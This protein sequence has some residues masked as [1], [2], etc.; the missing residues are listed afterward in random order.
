MHYQYCSCTVSTVHALS[1]L[2]VSMQ[3]TLQD[4]S[5]LQ[6]CKPRQDSL[7]Q[8]AFKSQMNESIKGLIVHWQAWAACIFALLVVLIA[9]GSKTLRADHNKGYTCNN[10][11]TNTYTIAQI[12][13]TETTLCHPVAQP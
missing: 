12:V 11:Q 5:H 8:Q 7:A 2:P 10:H 4:C 3:N 1:A 6:L 9:Q 13:N